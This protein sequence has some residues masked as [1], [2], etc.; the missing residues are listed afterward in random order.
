MPSQADCIVAV[1]DR[2]MTDC[3]VAGV[4]HKTES[5][6]TNCIVAVTNCQADC[7]VAFTHKIE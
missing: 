6:Q 7:I 3:L 5:S 4:T 2:V 1:T